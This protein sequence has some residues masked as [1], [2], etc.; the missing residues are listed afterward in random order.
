MATTASIARRDIE[1]DI[2][3]S[4]RLGHCSLQVLAVHGG[5]VSLE[6]DLVTEG[7]GELDVVALVLLAQEVTLPEVRAQRRV[8]TDNN[9]H[10]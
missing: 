9:S 2:Q 7:V 6:V 4:R 1:V 8:V 3:S 10:V 5:A